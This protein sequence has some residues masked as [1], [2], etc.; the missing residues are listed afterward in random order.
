[1]REPPLTDRQRILKVFV[2]WTLGLAVLVGSPAISLAR[3]KKARIVC[4]CDC[5]YLTQGGL[6]DIERRDLQRPKIKALAKRLE[7]ETEEPEWIPE[8]PRHQRWEATPNGPVRHNIPADLE[9]D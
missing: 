3:P 1:M 4:V 5:K 7:E 2:V 9:Q 6:D 8:V